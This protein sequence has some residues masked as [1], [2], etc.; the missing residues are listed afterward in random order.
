MG[1]VTPRPAADHT[2]TRKSNQ[3]TQKILYVDMDNTLVDFQSGIDRLDTDD[4]ATYEGRYDDAPGIF[5]L[6]DPM[7]GA[8][9][10]YRRLADAY[11]TYILSTAPWRNPS[12]WHDKVEWV[13]AHLGVDEGT[14]A[15]KRLIL[16]HHKNLN[17]GD[18]LVDDRPTHRGADR[19]EG[20]V[21]HFGSEEF[22]DW[23]SVVERLLP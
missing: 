6:M 15:Y 13:H 16:S 18:F 21:I 7:V 8:V 3:M 19:F 9:D 23:A 2:T 12:A 10:A 5:A 1:R 14:P 17:R 20:T 11:D 4:K 22:P